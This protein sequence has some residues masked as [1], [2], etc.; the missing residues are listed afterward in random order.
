M[1]EGFILNGF[2]TMA[3]KDS[4]DSLQKTTF[5]GVLEK[6]SGQFIP[7]H[8]DGK[9]I[10]IVKTAEV[11]PG[12]LVRHP[13]PLTTQRE[14]Q[15]QAN[16]DT[17]SRDQISS[18]IIWCG[19]EGQL[20][21]IKRQAWEQVKRFGFYQNK[22]PIWPSPEELASPKSWWSVDFALPEHWMQYVRAYNMINPLKLLYPIAYAIATVTD[23]FM[24]ANCLIIMTRGYIDADYSDDDNAVLSMIQAKDSI[25]TLTSK[26]S[27]WIYLYR[28]V[29]GYTDESKITTLR[30]LGKDIPGSA[31]LHK[32]RNSTGAPPLGEFLVKTGVLNE[33]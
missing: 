15:W 10:D 29:A 24:L 12:I 4:G 9:I 7:E 17:T 8:A 11:K 14:F 25:D 27:R 3:S 22:I 31:I 30:S 32:H 6:R 2:I 28:P 26:L 13:T 20:D 18:Y 23:L 33:F 5:L 16:P 1:F 21:M 19:Y